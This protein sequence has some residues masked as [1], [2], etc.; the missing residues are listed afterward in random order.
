MSPATPR[1]ATK[2]A[3]ALA[4]IAG[5]GLAAACASTEPSVGAARRDADGPSTSPASTASSAR[6]DALRAEWGTCQRDDECTFVS[7]GCCSTTPVNRT[8]SEPA[9]A[10]LE[11][12]GAPYCPVKTACGPG[13]DGTFAGTPGACIAGR[14]ACDPRATL[15]DNCLGK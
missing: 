12:S 3:R 9:M 15:V 10:A 8:F 4:A 7:L 5:F 6:A 13:S 11:A 1:P 14:C 2:R